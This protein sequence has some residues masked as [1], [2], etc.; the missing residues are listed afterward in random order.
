MLII[1]YHEN[2]D[3]TRQKRAKGY[4]STIIKYPAKHMVLRD[5]GGPAEA[6]TLDLCDVNAAL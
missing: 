1:A 3:Q 6:R 4:F 2:L 5:G